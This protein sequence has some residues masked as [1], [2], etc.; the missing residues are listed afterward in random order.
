MGLELN[1]YK[2]II[3]DWNGTLLDDA[4]L[5][6]EILNNIL[7]KYAKP[8]VTLEQ[9]AEEFDFPV[10]SY[11]QKLGFDFDREPFEVI[12]DDYIKQYDVKRFEC[13]LQDD[14]ES[15]LKYFADNGI[16]QSIL[17]AYQQK[18]LE[19][20][21]DFF[22]LRHYFARLVG[23]NDYYAKSKVENGRVLMKKLG[24]HSRDVMLIGDTCHDFEVAKA[25]DIDCVLIPSGHNSRR[26]LMK[27]QATLLNCL[28]EILD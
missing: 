1:K 2:H 5:C 17:T 13:R 10:K 4:R 3:W 24:L 25:L 22:A 18:M 12:A 6:V 23:L 20:I 19:E 9:Y 21:I 11:Y 8:P 7:R 27:C 14:A 15:V 16:E 26:K 28:G